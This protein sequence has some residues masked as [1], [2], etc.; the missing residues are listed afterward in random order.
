MARI[1]P[2]E[3]LGR[4]EKGKPVAA[5]LLLG[6][7]VY[8]R[9]AC[10]E[11]LIERFVPEAAR[12]WAVSRYSAERGETQAALEQAQTMA[13]LSPQQVVFLEDAEAIE[14]LGEKNRDEAVAQLG[15]YLEDPA[16]FTVLVVE[17]TVLDQRM[18]LGK[19]LAEKALVVECGLGENAGERQAAAVAL[20]RAI[21]KEQGVE[22]EK[23]AAEDLA[24]FVA[25]DLMRLKTEIDKLATYAADKEIIARADVTALVIS[26]K[27]TTVWELADLLASRQSKK[28]LEFLDRLL[29]DGEEPLQM[30]GAITWMYRKL[31]EASEVRGVTN[32][33]QAA[34]ALGMRAE[35]A[36]LALQNARKISKP[37]LLAGLHALRN[38]DDRLKGAGAEPRTVMEFLVAQLT[39]GEAK[40]AGG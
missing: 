34:R 27:T 24:E 12:T 3:L 32:G 28:A 22:F 4:L 35:Q 36:E 25:A 37:R 29:R 7:E 21:G 17:V 26:E 11:Q 30:L 15:A 13:M 10:R 14:K 8:L 5:I 33:W 18:K 20:A 31:I 6:E 39:S 1:S 19:M 38:A 2:E 16:P 23:G 9:D 40:A